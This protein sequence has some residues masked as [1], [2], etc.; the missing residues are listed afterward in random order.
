MRRP[1]LRLRVGELAEGDVADEEAGDPF[2]AHLAS[3]SACSG[4]AVGVL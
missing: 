2:D 3:L 4:Q 1:S